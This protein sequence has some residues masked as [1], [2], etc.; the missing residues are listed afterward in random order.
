MKGCAGSLSDSAA[1]VVAGAAGGAA[2]VGAVGAGAAWHDSSARAATG[3]H[4]PF[5]ASPRRRRVY[6]REL[7]GDWA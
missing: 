3:G 4:E 1:A 2:T 6:S 7:A 5:I